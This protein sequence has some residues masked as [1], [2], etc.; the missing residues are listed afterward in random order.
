[1]RSAGGFVG[2]KTPRQDKAFA[3]A[4]DLYAQICIAQGRL[5]S[6]NDEMAKTLKDLAAHVH[7]LVRAHVEDVHA[8]RAL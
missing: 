6:Q 5:H 2:K 3:D 8:R 7:R 4:L 1:M